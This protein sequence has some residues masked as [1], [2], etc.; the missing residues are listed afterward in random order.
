MRQIGYC[1]R[2]HRRRYG[3]P[4]CF[5]TPWGKGSRLRWLCRPCHDLLG[6]KAAP[7]TPWC[8]PA[9]EQACEGPAST[10]QTPLA[11][12]IPNPD[13]TITCVWVTYGP[14]AKPGQEEA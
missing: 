5:V 14:K 12:I 2:C 3:V 9:T 10:H 11:T 1:D 13:G 6:V 4:I 8:L 7:P